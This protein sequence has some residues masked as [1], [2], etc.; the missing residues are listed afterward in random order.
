MVAEVPEFCK[1]GP[2]KFLVGLEKFIDG[3][4]QVSL[5]IRGN[6]AQADA[7]EVLCK[8][9]MGSLMVSG[10]IHGHL[11]ILLEG[12]RGLRDKDHCFIALWYDYHDRRG[13]I[14]F[15]CCGCP[16]LI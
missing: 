8:Q 9:P 12:A 10:L 1:I 16:Y 5:V 15:F 2:Q 7:G 14:G 3:N 6:W 13:A 11:Y 4:D